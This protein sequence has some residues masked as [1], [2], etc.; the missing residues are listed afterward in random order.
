MWPFVKHQIHDVTVAIVLAILR[1]QHR[2]YTG[3][4]RVAVFSNLGSGAARLARKLRMKS[5]IF[6]L[7]FFSNLCA[8][9]TVDGGS[10]RMIIMW[11][12]LEAV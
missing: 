5:L 4:F 1:N 3:E 12:Y 7:M 6:I 10:Y 11:P 9:E 8:V 2:E